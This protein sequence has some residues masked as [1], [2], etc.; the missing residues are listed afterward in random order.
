MSD[1]RHI[2]VAFRTRRKRDN[3][4]GRACFSRDRD[5][6]LLLRRAFPP[7]LRLLY[8]GQI[9]AFRARQM[10]DLSRRRD[11]LY[12]V[13]RISQKR[14]ILCFVHKKSQEYGGIH[15]LF[16]FSPRTKYAIRFEFFSF[17]SLVALQEGYLPLKKATVD[18]ATFLRAL[19]QSG[20]TLF[21][22]F[23]QATAR[24]APLPRKA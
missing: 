17:S 11:L 22:C 13:L 9:R 2:V 18:G 6:C 20:Q 1:K 8:R 19:S 14:M 16:L 24:L 21:I 10:R 3:I 12:V 7:L 4:G 23:R 5:N 15:R